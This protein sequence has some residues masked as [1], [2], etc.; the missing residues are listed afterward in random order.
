MRTTGAGLE[1]TEQVIDNTWNSEKKETRSLKSLPNG[2]LSAYYASNFHCLTLILERFHLLIAWWSKTFCVFHT[3][4]DWEFPYK[5][6]APSDLFNSN[7]QMT[8]KLNKSS[9]WSGRLKDTTSCRN[10]CPKAILK[11]SLKCFWVLELLKQQIQCLKAH[12]AQS[13]FHF[14]E[15]QT[16]LG[17]LPVTWC[18][19]RNK[20][21]QWAPTKMH[22]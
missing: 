8:K 9:M 22:V 17:K 1:R 7:A 18:M 11:T 20:K 19:V 4:S 3:P 12:E 6:N 2:F 15:G 16:C 13:W 5:Q 21:S 10:K 14:C